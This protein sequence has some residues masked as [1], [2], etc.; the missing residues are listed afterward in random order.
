MAITQV[1]MDKNSCRY[2]DGAKFSCSA[3]DY[4]TMI[5]YA[6]KELEA[7]R[8]MFGKDGVGGGW[9]GKLA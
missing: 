5:A 2:R 8:V 1:L 7:Q 9:I 4:P 3:G 6:T